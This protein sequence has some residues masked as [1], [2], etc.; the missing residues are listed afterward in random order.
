M[1]RT[2]RNDTQP[3]NHTEDS[4]TMASANRQP[5][6]RDPGSPLHDRYPTMDRPEQAPIDEATW[7]RV[8]VGQHV[9][10]RQGELLGRINTKSEYVFE[11][12]VPEGLLTTRELY[13]PHLAVVRVDGDTVHLGWSK[14]ELIDNYEHYRR[15]HYGHRAEP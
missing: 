13:V 9:W 15:Y 11:V 7:S 2:S 14:Q 1:T 12:D 6:D 5:A 3:A 4:E 10:S 8:R